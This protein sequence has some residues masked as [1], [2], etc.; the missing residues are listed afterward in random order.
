MYALWHFFVVDLIFPPHFIEVV[1]SGDAN[2]VREYINEGV[3]V[4]ELGPEGS[5][6]LDEAISHGH[7][8]IARIL[9][10]AGAVAGSSSHQLLYKSTLLGDTETVRILIDAGTDVNAYF[11]DYPPLHAAISRGDTEAMRILI[12]AGAD[13]NVTRRVSTSLQGLPMIP[14]ED[15]LL[16]EAVSLGNA[17]VMRILIEAGAD[18]DTVNGVGDP[19][20]HEAISQGHVEVVHTL[21]DLGADVNATDSRGYKPLDEAVW[22]ERTEIQRMLVEA[23]AQEVSYRHKSADLHRAV[24]EG[25]V[26][27]VKKLIAEGADV[28]AKDR[29]GNPLLYQAISGAVHGVNSEMVR[30][31]IDARANVNDK[32]SKDA[33]PL[34]AAMAPAAN[35]ARIQNA[36]RFMAESPGLFAKSGDSMSTPTPCPEPEEHEEAVQENSLEVMRTLLDAGADIDEHM[37]FFAES[38]GLTDIAQLLKDAGAQY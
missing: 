31:L 29:H 30:V 37:L 17:E 25:D 10:D 36:C 3:D 20:L 6:P 19:L 26:D 16:H 34:M 21:I 11:V 28:N 14:A 22:H 2:E 18:V 1:Q 5:L 27:R 23:G 33:S 32:N 38:Q 8:E 24:Q 9:V 12:E 13:V 35:T 4:N 7:T 15:P